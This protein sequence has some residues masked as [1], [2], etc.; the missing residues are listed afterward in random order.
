MVVEMERAVSMLNRRAL[1]KRL[2][3]AGFAAPVIASILADGAW[4]QD[5]ATPMAEAFPSPFTTIPPERRPGQ[6]AGVDRRRSAIH[7]RTAASTSARL[8][9]SVEPA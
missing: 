5:A 8:R 1:I 4:A 9:T 7:S 2:A 6:I 3:A